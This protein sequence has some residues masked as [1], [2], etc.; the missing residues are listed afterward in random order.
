MKLTMVINSLSSGGAERV[1]VTLANHWAEQE[2]DPQV[3]TLADEKKDFYQLHPGVSRITLNLEGTSNNAISAIRN[4]IRRIV[5]LRRILLAANPDIALGF[6]P[7]CNILLGMA[8]VG[9]GIP[10]IGSEHIHPPTMPLG[11]SW[12]WL[13]RKFY[14][15]LKAVTALT[16]TSRAWIE[17]HTGARCVP[18]IPNPVTYPLPDAEPRVKPGEIVASLGGKRLLISVGRLTHVK[19]FDYLLDAFAHLQKKH[20]DWR[21]VILGEGPLRKALEDQRHRLGLDAVVAMPGAVG[22]IGEWYNAADLY[23]MT[24]RFEGFG[25]TLAEALAYGVPAVAMDCETGP[26]DILRDEVG[27]LVPVGDTVRLIDSLDRMISDESVLARFSKNAIR[28]R[29]RYATE[30]IAMM[31]MTIFEKFRRQNKAYVN[32]NN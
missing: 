24:S 30:R 26:R 21:L 5:A 7:S 31:W 20:I 13:R 23:V 8:A 27:L 2:L 28:A 10:V 4:N 22:N 3:V 17:E 25:N 11:R 1:A 29:E 12:T 14:P 32:K 18:V 6:M 19:G 15:R 16:E 9:T